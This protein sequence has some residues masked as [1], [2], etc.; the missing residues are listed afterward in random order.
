MM[1]VKLLFTTLLWRQAHSQATN[2]TSAASAVVD[3]GTN[4]DNVIIYPR[5][6]TFE[7]LQLLIS[8]EIGV[9]YNYYNNT[10]I[11]DN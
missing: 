4:N 6:L 3:D 10:T 5:H 7:E 11:P 2:T 8:S 1:I 9:E